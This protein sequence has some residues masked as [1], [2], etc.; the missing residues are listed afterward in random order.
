MT[1]PL[2]VGI[3]GCGNIANNH[4]EA[5]ESLDTATVVAVCDVDAARATLFAT[6]RGIPAAVDSV[7]ALLD[8]GV[9]VISVCTPHPT[10]EAVVVEAAA[11][12]V[13]VLC[14]KPIA[15]SA[16]SAKRMTD[17]AAEAGVK[18]GVI[19]QR[20]FWPA[21]QRIRNAIDDGRIGTPIL[22]SCSILL[23]RDV[24]YYSSAA[25]RGTWETDGGGAL[26]TQGI[27]YV[28][29]LQWYMGDVVEVTAHYNTLVFQEHIEVEDVVVATLRFASGAVA[30]IHAT[31]AA[32]PSLG[33]RVAVT[34]STGAT[35]SLTEF[36]EGAEGVNDLWSVP[37]EETHV[38]V[39]AEGVGRN[40]PLDA[41][42]AALVPFHTLQIQD[43][44][45]AVN[46]D[47]EPAVSG[48]EALKSLEIIAAIYKSSETGLPVVPDYSQLA[49]HAA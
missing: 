27:H 44:I 33:A 47:T 28:D 6:E 19:F 36:P 8:L 7:A 1:T 48:F 15:I 4:Y 39:Y 13:N 40:I 43:F 22:G 29:I 41:I 3:V 25:W 30:T 46:S 24:A 35:V 49:P 21:A 32:S 23:H 14:E 42:N 38:D 11:R 2:R 20:R 34:G 31:T 10:H 12:G 18:L 16:E 26:M 5:Y 45:N 37:G 9:D 17:A